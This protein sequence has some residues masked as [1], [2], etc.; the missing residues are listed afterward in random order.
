MRTAASA[1]KAILEEKGISYSFIAG[2]TGISID[3]LSKTFLGKRKLT[4][5]E[6]IKIC[7]CTDID[8]DDLMLSEPK[9]G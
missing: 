8:I 1:I 6:M 2:K 9:A 3:A 4:A 5:D 7:L